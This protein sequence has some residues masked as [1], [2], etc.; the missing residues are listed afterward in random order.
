MNGY[1]KLCGFAGCQ[2]P[3]IGRQITERS[4]DFMTHD[5]D[6]GPTEGTIVGEVA[7]TDYCARVEQHP[8]D[9]SRVRVRIGTFYT[10]DHRR[11]A[12]LILEQIERILAE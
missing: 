2:G 6:L 9:R 11:R 4:I 5:V 3:D 10:K 8:G 12:L 1:D 7:G